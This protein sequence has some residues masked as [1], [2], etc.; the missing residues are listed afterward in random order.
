MN[1]NGRGNAKLVGFSGNKEAKINL[2]DALFDLD[3]LAMITGNFSEPTIQDVSINKKYEIKNSAITL[4]EKPNEGT[5]IRVFGVNEGGGMSKKFTQGD[6][7]G[8][9]VFTYDES[10]KEMKFF[11][12][13][14]KDGDKVKTFYDTKTKTTAP[15]IKVTSDKFGGT[16]KVVMDCLVRDEETGFDYAAQITVPKAKFE[17]NFNF[18]F[19]ADGDPATFTLPLEVLKASDSTDMWTMV[20]YDAEDLVI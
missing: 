1:L 10:T 8:A 3:A 15:T 17:D 12:S 20:I 5:T 2:E 18:A 7:L 13:D 16:F 4:Q 11:P 6:T 14:L 19:S 9:G